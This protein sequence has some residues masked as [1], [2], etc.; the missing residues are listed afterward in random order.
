MINKLNGMMV[1][2]DEFKRLFE[3]YAKNKLSSVTNGEIHA[4]LLKVIEQT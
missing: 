3:I 4:G 2:N 1:G